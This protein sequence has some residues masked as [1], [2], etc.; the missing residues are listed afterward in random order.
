MAEPVSRPSMIH[1]YKLTE[2]SLYA[3]VSVGLDPVSIFEVL[4][5]LSKT[6]VPHQI[7]KFIDR[8]TASV[9]KIKMV[10]KDNHFFVESQQ[11]ESLRTVLKD[12]LIRGARV[13]LNPEH[14]TGGDEE[15]LTHEMISA[16]VPLFEHSGR[17]LNT[18][19]TQSSIDK[20][21]LDLWAM[22]D[23]IDNGDLEV[24]ASQAEE[25][26]IQSGTLLR[27]SS[28]QPLESI[29]SENIMTTEIAQISIPSEDLEFPI[30]VALAPTN[31]LISSFE[32]KPDCVEAVKKRSSEMGL[33][34]IEEYDFR[35]DTTL[36]KLDI[37]LKSVTRLRPYQEKS[38]NKMF[39]NGRARSGII[40][41][42][43]G[44]GKTLVGVTAA[45]TI[46]KSCLVLC[47]SGLSV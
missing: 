6:A 1:E 33:P 45:C 24:A 40:V 21:D 41:L 17:Q 4:D 44:A 46:K 9:G 30:E 13:L 23:E 5:R 16:P 39:G 43:C 29:Y 11:P 34:M 47:T 22:F 12:D 20:A 18:N 10:L 37:D 32:I 2:Y 14:E 15:F 36:P 25:A 38:L 42:P 8:H 7:K 28:T 35:I 31:G 19:V 26:A 27:S 3:A